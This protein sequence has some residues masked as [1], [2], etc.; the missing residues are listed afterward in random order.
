MDGVLV[1]L[2]SAILR[3]RDYAND[4]IDVEIVQEYTDRLAEIPGIFSLTEPMPEAIESFLTLT[5]RFDTYIIST[6]TLENPDNLSRSGTT[7]VTFE[8]CK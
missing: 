6:S 7:S 4:R 1:D 8:Y 2:D 3:R 5:T